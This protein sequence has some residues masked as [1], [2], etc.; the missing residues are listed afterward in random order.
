VIAY[1]VVIPS[2]GRPQ[3]LS[4]LRALAFQPDPLPGHVFVVDDRRRRSTPVCDAAQVPSLLRERLIVL[5]G[6]AA[7]PASARNVGWRAS[8]AEWVVFLDDD[9]IPR[10]GWTQ[11]LQHDLANAAADVGAVQG[12]IV[13][14]LP[15]GRRPTDWERNVAGLQQAVWATADMAYRR[16][17]LEQVGGF[18]ERFPRAYREDADL[19]LRTVAAGWRVVAGDRVI[20]HPVRPAGSWI[21]VRLQKGNADDVLMRRLHGPG[22]RERAHVPPGRRPWHLATVAAGAL[23]AAGVVARRRS[24][25][26]VGG[27]AWAA[28]TAHFAVRRVAPGPRTTDEIATLAVTSVAIPPVAVWHFTRAL[29][30]HRDVR[31]WPW[32]PAAGRQGELAVEERAS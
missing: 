31:P 25:A 20:D 5:P 9:V 21:S 4:T 29:A 32:P 24:L 2:I 10:P 6:D 8:P 19:G 16:R 12:R 1:D 3:L 11:W 30:Q 26:L 18:D 14:P 17:V 28:L 13:V 15:E 7:G 22:W 27:L 23:G